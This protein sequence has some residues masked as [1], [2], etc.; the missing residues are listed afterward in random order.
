MCED[1]PVAAV[2]RRAVLRA[3]VLGGGLVAAG[4]AQLW[5]PTPASAV[6]AQPNI[7]STAD[8][9][10]APARGTIQILNPRPTKIIVHHTATANSSDFSRAHAF[11]LARSIQQSHFARGFIDTGQ[12]F[13]ISRGGFIMAGRHHSLT[14]LNQGADHVLGAHCTGQNEESVGIENEG[15]YTNVQI[16]DDHYTKLVRLCAYICQQYDIA[17]ARIFGHRDFVATECPG[18]RLYN[19]IPTLR[20]DV[21]ALL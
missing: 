4:A 15:T 20:A 17:P 5:L 7:F 9:G 11:A 6:V 18:D 12:H 10:A 3:G 21:R 13:T 19:R 14:E 2:N 8:W 16:R 1:T